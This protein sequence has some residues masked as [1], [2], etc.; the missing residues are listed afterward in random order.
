VRFV[1]QQKFTVTVIGERAAASNAARD[2]TRADANDA[3]DTPLR[4]TALPPS[5]L[6][7]CASS[8]AECDGRNTEGAGRPASVARA[9]SVIPSDQ[10]ARIV[11]AEVRPTAP[12]LPL[13]AASV[14]PQ[15]FAPRIVQ[16]SAMQGVRRGGVDVTVAALTAYF[17]IATP[18]LLETVRAV[19]AGLSVETMRDSDWVQFGIAAQQALSVVVAQR[20]AL[21]EMAV[22]RR[23]PA[24]LARI[25]ALVEDIAE[26]IRGGFLRRSP[27]MVWLHA[28]GELK[29]AS[30]QLG[31]DRETIRSHLTALHTLF[32][33][34]ERARH[35]IEA[36]TLAGEYVSHR[37]PPE[38]ANVLQARLLAL[39]TMQA[40]AK[41]TMLAMQQDRERL[42]ELV[43]LIDDGVLVRL[44]ALQTHLAALPERPS[45]TQRFLAR[46]I[47]GDLLHCF[48]RTTTWHS[49]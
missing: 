4:A 1:T 15:S 28:R 14:I 25:H 9:P 17:P 45:T 40:N 2:D 41:Q 33:E 47:A 13:P 12:S 22:N 35:Q 21:S 29:E 23:V 36:A 31:D 7:P 32:E 37:L 11:E 3:H 19:L 46:D 30:A 39:V 26:A 34:A 48:A 43:L 44:P 42:T 49:R 24:L 38:L 16:T 6:P 27:Q 10:A 18:A 20:L 5:A 8:A